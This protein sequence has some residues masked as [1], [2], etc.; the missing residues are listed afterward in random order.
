[1]IIKPAEKLRGR[2]RLPGD[3]S[4]SHRAAMLSALARGATEIK[5]FASSADC[6]ATL[7]CLQKLGVEV[8]RAGGST[9]FVKGFGKSGLR[10][11]ATVL[12]CENSGTTARLLAGILAGQNF[13]T[14]LVGDESLSAR[15]MRR[16]IAPLA[17]MG[18]EITANGD[19]LPLK[20]EGKQPLTAIKYLLPVHSAQVKSCILLAGLFA[21]GETV[22]EHEIQNPKSEIPPMRDHTERMLRWFGAK[23]REDAAASANKKIYSTTI[24]G[25]TE[26]TAQGILNVPSDIS[27]AAFFVVAAA[28]LKNSEIQL[29]N[30]GLNPSRS[31]ILTVL[32][33]F[34]AKIEIVSEREVCN[35]T[36]GDL[37]V[38]GGLC[39]QSATNDNVLRGETTAALIDEL[40]ILA[41]FG[42]QMV[43]GLEIRDAG[44]LRVKESDRI[45][46]VVE[47]LRRMNAKVEEFADGLRVEKSALRG[48]KIESYGDHRIAM[49]FSIAALLADGGAEIN[50]A[51]SVKVSFPEFFEVLKNAQR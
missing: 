8:R 47:N 10:E 46:A 48:A 33:R 6:A 11:P 43:N 30:V 31:A 15:P 9:V 26:M 39:E 14:T 17:A 36:V 29:E 41:I 5:N 51:D 12:N 28:C 2:L 22:V 24:D 1:M 38:R 19:C 3:K 37:I 16:I 13:A 23:L 45:A 42:T 40:P 21:D 18:A 4:I 35:E 27:S 34:G 25:Q 49:A 32:Q 50:G 7:D 20:I 44:E